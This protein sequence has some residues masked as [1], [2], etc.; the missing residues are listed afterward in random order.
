MKVAPKP[1]AKKA[2]KLAIRYS[3]IV[4]PIL[5]PDAR[6]GHRQEN[7]TFA[8]LTCQLPREQ[9]GPA[10]TL[11]LNRLSGGFDAPVMLG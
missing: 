6:I 7:A 10:G 4:L 5:C 8:T 3:M 2:A 11:F 9:R 1:T